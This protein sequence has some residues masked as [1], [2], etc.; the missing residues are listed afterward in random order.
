[1]LRIFIEDK[2]VELNE[3]VTAALTKQF[4]DLSNP[5]A[6]INDWSKTVSIPFTQ[7]NH[8][9]FGHIYCPDRIIASGSSLIGIYFDPYKKLDFRIQWGETVLMTG[10][11]KMNEVKQ[12]EGKGTYEIT[13]FGQLG[14][15]FQEMQKITFDTSSDDTDYI[16]DGSEYVEEK[17]NKTLVNSSWT[18][19]GQQTSTLYPKYFIPTGTTT[20]VQHPAYHVTDIIGF[21]PNNSF[22]DGFDYKAY[23]FDTVTSK[24][25]ADVLESSGFAEETGVAPETAIP[26][27]M[28]PRE[29]GEYRSYLQL[30]YIYWNKL[31]KI[32]QAKAESVT[33][34]QFEYDTSWFNTKNPYWYNLVYMLKPFDA[35]NGDIRNN[36]YNNLSTSFSSTAYVNIGDWTTSSNYTQE[37]TYRMNPL[38][39][40]YE[41]VSGV[42]DRNSYHNQF[43]F[44]DNTILNIHCYI[45]TYLL[46]V[47]QREHIK[48]TNGLLFT[49][50]ATGSNGATQTQQFLI[51]HSGSSLTY[52]NAVTIDTGNSGDDASIGYAIII[53]TMDAYFNLTKDVFGSYVTL[54]TKAKWLYN[55]YPISGSAT[56]EIVLYYG[57]STQSSVVVG[58]PSTIELIIPS[59]NWFHSQAPFTL[60]D[61]WNNDYNVFDEILKY[62]KMFRIGIFTD[63]VNKKIIFK[64]FSKYFS[65]YTVKDWSDKLDKSKDYI[66]KPITFEDKYVLFNYEDSDTKLGEEYKEKY[67]VNYGEYRLVTDYN[68][69]NE[70][71]ELFENVMGSITNT[72]N[73]LSWTN[74]FD[75][76]KIIY[77]FPN[78]LYIY[79]KNDDNKQVDIFGSF[80]LHN[81]L[82]SFSDEAS[83][84]LRDVYISDDT[85]FQQ[86]TN[87]YFYTQMNNIMTNVLTYPNLDI[88]KG[89]NIC[90]FNVPMENYTYLNNYSGKESIYTNLWKTYLDERYN[91]QNKIVTCYLRLSPSDYINFDYN[92]FI[93][94]GNQIYMIN[95][96]YDYD[97]NSTD[98]TKVDLI[99]IQNIGG[100]ANNEF[101][102][103]LDTLTLNWSYTPHVSGSTG[104]NY[105][106]GTFNSVSQVKFANGTTTYTVS[107]MKFTIV[108]NTTVHVETTGK[109]VQEADL[110][111]SVTLKNDYFTVSFP[112]V[113]YSVYP[114]PFISIYDNNNT[115]LLSTV[116]SSGL[117]RL[118]WECTD[119]D[120]TSNPPTVLYSVS[121]GVGNIVVGTI[122]ESSW[123]TYQEGEDEYFAYNN[124]NT[125]RA[126]LSAGSTVTFTVVDYQGWTK[127]VTFPVN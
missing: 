40:Q 30:P 5:T 83:L 70:T 50:T 113:R 118:H 61:L 78:E 69:N 81:G 89:D 36:L 72:D 87:T 97:V 82:R 60:N 126:S 2:E 67:G 9:L 75:N 54:S 68:F 102:K 114:Y 13:L 45:N 99:T 110:N 48:D 108:N 15:I 31:F 43:N 76:K 1:M 124:W 33:G 10:Y 21:A 65:E 80:Y 106:I 105:D 103:N 3:S 8:Q 4:E 93:T 37:Y 96:I 18:S 35:K 29:I 98:S 95:K 64:P 41:Q 32:F 112:V 107:G 116:P 62:C 63:D 16:I 117:F 86:A 49:V 46:V 120:A 91:V 53:P 73:V 79:N 24:K 123:N 39:T 51:R 6:I 55:S 11:A 109:Y 27:G 74:L 19:S 115:T 23:Q 121:G 22:S 38:G 88:V 101:I 56:G 92:H 84:Y 44:G 28:L 100:Y 85:A 7:S 94:I 17:I 58:S 12:S 104:V 34:Y 52:G 66:V 122:W 47:T 26:D 119:T 125:C 20:P 59:N 42:M 25:F 90:L 77:S 111:L 71:S 127:T 14:K 57:N